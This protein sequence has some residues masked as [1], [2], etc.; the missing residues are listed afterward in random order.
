MTTDGMKV[1]QKY[2]TPSPDKAVQSTIAA[3][4]AENKTIESDINTTYKTVH[5]LDA[6]WTRLSEEQ[7]DDLE[8]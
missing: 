1:I 5:E 7:L 6:E 8:N 3:L 2:V 4:R